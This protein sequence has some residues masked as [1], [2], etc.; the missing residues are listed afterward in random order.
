MS[1]FHRHTHTWTYSAPEQR[2]VIEHKLIMGTTTYPNWVQPRTCACGR[3]E[4][5]EMKA[6]ARR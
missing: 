6:E 1:L 5:L 3:V 2:G 4:W